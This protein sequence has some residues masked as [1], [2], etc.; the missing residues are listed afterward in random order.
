MAATELTC[1]SPLNVVEEKDKCRLILDMR[2]VNANLIVPKFK[3]EGL[4]RVADLARVGD[5]MFS[6]DIKSGYHHI[7]IH[8]SCWK[9][10]GFEFDRRA[11]AFRSLPFGL[12]TAS[13]VFM[14]LVKQL[15]RRWREQGM[16]LV[17]YVDDILFIC[18]S[19]AGIRAGIHMDYRVI[20]VPDVKRCAVGTLILLLLVTATWHMSPL[21]LAEAKG[22][23]RA[24]YKDSCPYLE[25]IV[26]EIVIDEYRKDQAVPAPLLRLHF[27]DCFVQGCDGS[28]LL[29]ST[30]G[31]K[32]EKD[33]PPNLSLNGFNIIDRIK[34]AVEAKCPGVV[35]CADIAAL[36]ARDGVSLA[37]GPYI[38]T[39]L[40]RRDSRT[41]KADQAVK[42]LPGHQ[43]DVNAL[44][45]NFAAI[46]LTLVDL[47]TLS[48][49]HTIGESHCDTVAHRIAPNRDPTI[50]RSMR[51]YLEG[52]C[53]APKVDGTIPVVL[54]IKSAKR[55]DNQY[56][57]NLQRKFGLL[58]S[59][60]V[61][62]IDARTKDLVNEFAA[63]KKSF[64]RHFRHSM[65]RMGSFGA[66]TGRKGEIRRTC[67]VVN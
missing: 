54:D 61:L 12:A 23:S 3:Y 57:K 60:Q 55:F 25:T 53:K 5:W 6:I 50:A 47:V 43:M 48:G 15:A 19:K 4:S 20:A 46:N 32:A 52:H 49:G 56:F 9:F 64:F 14:Q 11:Y 41:S 18:Q 58:S 24:Y 39:Q 8:P 2:K 26:R 59:D 22:L 7:D 37:G 28:V 67:S 31:N 66:L 1:I 21:Q 27:H 17:P 44:L 40:G 62:M 42:F 63:D 35:S 38:K 36:A 13:F 10:L 30:P 51:K 16:R 29:N 45:S 33:A 34:A 65:V